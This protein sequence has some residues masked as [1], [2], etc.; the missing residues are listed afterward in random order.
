MKGKCYEYSVRAILLDPTL[1]LAKGHYYCPFTN[2]KYPHWWCVRKDG[3][4]YD[5][6]ASQFLSNGEG[7]YLQATDFVVCEV[8][9]KE[10][11]EKNAF[12]SGKHPACSGRCFEKM[13]L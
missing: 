11:A 9:G 12:W 10:V 7:E 5:P 6:T 4:I 13:V 8:C 1:I 3:S 2:R